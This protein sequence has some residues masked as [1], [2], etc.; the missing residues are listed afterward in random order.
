MVVTLCC[1]TFFRWRQERDVERF[2]QRETRRQ[3]RQDLDN[4]SSIASTEDVATL[5]DLDDEEVVSE[6]RNQLENRQQE[7]GK[8]ESQQKDI[9]APE[10]VLDAHGNI[11][12]NEESLVLRDAPSIEDVEEVTE[13]WND[14]RATYGSFRTVAQRSR[15]WS[16]HE[17]TRFYKALCTIGTDFSFMA[18]VFRQRSRE[19]LKRKFKREEKRNPHLINMALSE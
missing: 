14:L 4:F 8:E 19:E 6:Q 17:T 15:C 13:G 3:I 11:V 2:K 16:D 10:V 18:S 9:V 5:S 12:L 1:V 7:N